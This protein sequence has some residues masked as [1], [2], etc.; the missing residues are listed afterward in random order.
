MGMECNKPYIYPEDK[1]IRQNAATAFLYHL[2]HYNQDVK[3]EG[4]RCISVEIPHVMQQAVAEIQHRMQRGLCIEVNPS[5]NCLIGTFGKYDCEKHPILNFYN[6]GL[7]ID[8]ESGKKCS[9]IS[10]CINTDAPSVF[11]NKS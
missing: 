4:S 3:T 10:V 1:R 9:Q 8:N 2:Y 5:S 7:E 6:L 11:W